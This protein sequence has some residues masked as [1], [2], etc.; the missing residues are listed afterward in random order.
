AALRAALTRRGGAGAGDQGEGGGD[1]LRPRPAAAQGDPRR[2]GR[3][4]AG[5]LTM[6]DSSPGSDPFNELAYEF[7][8]RYRRGERPSPTEYA[9]RYP[10]LAD[11]IRELFPTL[12]M[13]ER[14][15]GEGKTQRV[16]DADPTGREEAISERMGDYRILREIGRG[17]MGVVYEAVQESLG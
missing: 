10:D 11:E 14:F 12:A 2:S 1:A 17:G 4:L 5:V 3:R 15:G 8:E 6:A 13:M 16:P 9:E 7:V